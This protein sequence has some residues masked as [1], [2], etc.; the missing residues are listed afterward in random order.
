MTTLKMLPNEILCNI[1]GM[2]STREKFKAR[3]V[4]RDWRNVVDEIVPFYGVIICNENH[5]EVALRFGKRRVLSLEFSCFHGYTRNSIPIKNLSFLKRVVLLQN[6]HVNALVDLVT[7]ADKLVELEVRNGHN[8]HFHDKDKTAALL[9]ALR[10]IKKLILPKYDLGTQIL[11][12][13]SWKHIIQSE[14]S[15]LQHLEIDV[16]PFNSNYPNFFELITLKPHLCDFMVQIEGRIEAYPTFRKVI[17][18]WNAEYHNSE[19]LRKLKLMGE[20]SYF[21]RKQPQ[22]WKTLLANQNNLE[23]LQL[24]DFYVP[25]PFYD[26]Y[27]MSLIEPVLT[28]SMETLHTIWLDISWGYDRREPRGDVDVE[29]FAHLPKLRELHLTVREIRYAVMHGEEIDYLR[30]I[31]NCSTVISPSLCKLVLHGFEF[32]TEEV[33]DCIKE[34]V[35]L[36]LEKVDF[37]HSRMPEISTVWEEFS[38]QARKMGLKNDVQTNSLYL[39]AEF[40]GVEFHLK[41]RKTSTC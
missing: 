40:I 27:N 5:D 39:P 14:M 33:N 6:I 26:G 8:S 7:R 18:V 12:F 36:D 20:A 34:L 38:S 22:Q 24:Y 29:I 4:C 37:Y 32:S 30:G 15:K 25:R 28:K 21:L 31:K 13:N 16:L 10:K 1:M 23:E 9:P 17:A 3:V 35:K 41:H 11:L 19:G 2:L